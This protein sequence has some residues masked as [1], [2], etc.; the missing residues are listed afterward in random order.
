MTTQPLKRFYK[1]AEAG[2]APGTPLPLHVVRLDGR[3]LKT[4]CG[5]TLGLASSAMA[6]AVAAEWQAQKDVIIPATMPLTQLANTMIDKSAGHERP[7]LNAEVCKYAES[8]LVCYLATH[9]PELVRRQEDSWLPL[10]VWLQAEKDVKLTPVRGI[11]YEQQDA[12]SLERIRHWVQELSPID[13]T[14]VQAVT[15]VTG[16]VVI[17]L[18]LAA[19]RITAADAYAAACADEIFQLETWGEDDIARKRLDHI[20]AEL[21]AC[22]RFLALAR[23]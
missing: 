1:Q 6:Q 21:D 10:L 20:K 15:G 18:A 7:Q 19:G 12:A 3:L 5:E 14:V 17:G 4:P 23:A 11:R 8:D 2:T 9:P 13:F 16:S 22:A